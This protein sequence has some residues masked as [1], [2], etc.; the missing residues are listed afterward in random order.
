MLT[1]DVT[2][3]MAGKNQAALAVC[4]QTKVIFSFK[5]DSHNMIFKRRSQIYIKFKISIIRTFFSSAFM[6]SF[7]SLELPQFACAITKFSKEQPN[8]AIATHFRFL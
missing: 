1:F 3:L 4:A 6:D 5:V 7:H 8:Y 2:T